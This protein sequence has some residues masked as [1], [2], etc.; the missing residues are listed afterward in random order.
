VGSVGGVVGLIG[1]LGGFFLPIAF[2]V[3]NDLIGVWTSCF[4]L[5]TL[6]IGIALV[7]MHFAIMRMDRR[8]MPELKGPRYLPELDTFKDGQ[9]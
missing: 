3:M 5:L 2:G 7:W 8:D 4:M 1:G 9:S 6:L